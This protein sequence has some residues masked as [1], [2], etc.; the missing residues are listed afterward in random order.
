MEDLKAGATYPD[1]GD[2]GSV[3]NILRRVFADGAGNGAQATAEKFATLCRVLRCL[4]VEHVALK[5]V[6]TIGANRL[7][8]AVAVAQLQ[9]TGLSSVKGIPGKKIV[10]ALRR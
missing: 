5:E 8:T 4:F 1:G 3:G 10:T 2:W 6:G 9:R 7:G